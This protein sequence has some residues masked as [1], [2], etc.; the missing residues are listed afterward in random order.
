MPDS[1]L[2]SR[3]LAALRHIADSPAARGLADDAA[4][5]AWPLGL[6]LVATHDMLVE[7][8]HFLPSCPPGDIGWK[9]AAVNLS[10]LAAMGARPVAMLMGAAFA[11]DRDA[12]WA[13]AFADGVGRAAR[14]FA[15]PLLGGDTVR[16]RRETVFSLTAIGSTPDGK[17]L[18]RA[19]GGCGDDL[20][21]SGAIGDSGLGLRALRGEAMPATAAAALV[22]RYRLPQPRL[23]LGLA[24]RGIASAMMDVSDGLLIDAARL[25]RASGWTAEISLAAMPV[26]ALARAALGGQL[27][28][29]QRLLLATAG[30]DY[31]LLFAAPVCRRADVIGAAHGAAL[32]VT[33]LGRLVA[34]DG[35]GGG[36]LR[37]LDAQLPERL[38]YLHD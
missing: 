7:G 31:E 17:A 35:P 25:A 20:W 14:K 4:V 6:D 21:V 9:L 30:D 28:M 5:L 12:A 8:V 11:P 37:L 10:D 2:E 38:G 18:G 3:F 34:P 16:S 1:G 36:H 24:L 22:K 13:E 27:V 33:R 29:E 19:G 26:S 23:R 32:P 15:A